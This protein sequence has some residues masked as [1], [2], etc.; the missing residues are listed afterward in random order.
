MS[1]RGR[2][3][4]VFDFA[5]AESANPHEWYRTPEACVDAILPHLGRPRSIL[6]LGCGDGAIGQA[7]R[8]R[9]GDAPLIVGVEIDATRA[10]AARALEG[11]GSARAYDHVELKDLLATPA[12][13]EDVGADLVISNPPFSLAEPFARRAFALVRPGGV[14]AF[15]LRLGWLASQSRVAFH[16]EFPCDVFVLPKRPSFTGNGKSDSADYAWLCWGIGRG[17]RW[18][19]LEV[20]S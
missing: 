20:P 9:L 12:P 16:R 13:K 19:V 6:D 10:T 11:P 2:Q 8:V 7:L 1:S 18:S 3:G 14:V 4:N 15:I 5:K 17:G